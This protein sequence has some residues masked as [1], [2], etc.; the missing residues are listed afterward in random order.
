V[1]NSSQNVTALLDES[2]GFVELTCEL[3]LHHFVH[4]NPHLSQRQNIRE[5]SSGS[6]S[7]SQMVKFELKSE[8]PYYVHVEHNEFVHPAT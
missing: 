3:C 2:Y 6:Q 8:N 1:P 7:M 4:W 5:L